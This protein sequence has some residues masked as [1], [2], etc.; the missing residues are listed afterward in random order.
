[1]SWRTTRKVCAVLAALLACFL[2]FNFIMW[3]KDNYY[4]ARK[5]WIG[6]LS[7]ALLAWLGCLVLYP[8]APRT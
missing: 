7:V 3:P 1:M 2:T 6:Q 8:K 4:W 5:L